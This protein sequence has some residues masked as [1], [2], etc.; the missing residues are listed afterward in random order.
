M[1]E[2]DRS[3]KFEPLDEN[4]WGIPDSLSTLGQAFR[5]GSLVRTDIQVLEPTAL[6]GGEEERLFEVVIRDAK[7]T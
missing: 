4:G 1:K 7:P 3:Y 5:G 6:Y 2:A